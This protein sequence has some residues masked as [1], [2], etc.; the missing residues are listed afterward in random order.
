[1]R[2][3]RALLLAAA[4]TVGAHVSRSTSVPP[5]PAGNTSIGA[6]HTLPFLRCE[7]NL[8]RMADGNRGFLY[9]PD[10]QGKAVAIPI[11]KDTCTGPLP[12]TSTLEAGLADGADGRTVPGSA[13]AAKHRA[14]ELL[15][16]DSVR[17]RYAE[18]TQYSPLPREGRGAT[19]ALFAGTRHGLVHESAI[20]R[21]LALQRN[22]YAGAVHRV[23]GLYDVLAVSRLTAGV[24][25]TKSCVDL[26]AVDIFGGGG[27]NFGRRGRAC[28][29]HRYG[30]E[31]PILT[32]PA[33]GGGKAAVSVMDSSALTLGYRAFVDPQWLTRRAHSPWKPD[34][35][36][37]LFP[38]V[39]SEEAAPVSLKFKALQLNSRTKA[40]GDSSS[41][42]LQSIA[43]VMC[44]PPARSFVT[45]PDRLCAG[46]Q[47]G[48]PMIASKVDDKRST[49]LS[50]PAP[51]RTG[52]VNGRIVPSTAR[53][54]RQLG[55]RWDM[56]PFP[57]DSQARLPVCEPVR[58]ASEAYRPEWLKGVGPREI[59][60]ASVDEVA[61]ARNMT[62]CRL[63]SPAKVSITLCSRLFSLGTPPQDFGRITHE[64][65]Q[66]A[67]AFN[68]GAFGVD[69]PPEPSGV[70]SVLLA[71]IVV[72]P[73]AM[74]VMAMILDV[75]RWNRHGIMT[76]GLVWAA[77]LVSL[78]G[79]IYLASQETTGAAMRAATVR[80]TLAV[81]LDL[82][83][84][85]AR[86]SAVTDRDL[87]G[88]TLLRAETAYVVAR[89][90]YRPRMLVGIAAGTSVA[91]LL[92]SVAAVA[93][94]VIR[95]RVTQEE[96]GVTEHV[97]GGETAGSD[98]IEVASAQRPTRLP[99]RLAATARHV[100]PAA[101]RL[102]RDSSAD[103]EARTVRE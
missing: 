87:T 82:E 74:A 55:V 92:L 60:P 71:I 33:K 69:P 16:A 76:L 17:G 91:Y 38:P 58:D 53:S 100:W 66:L 27:N 7:T 45:N 101:L 67:Q 103:S 59:N 10:E 32:V 41:S 24:C 94:A 88:L 43:Y 8:P 19:D 49:M 77:G 72:L 2:L 62:S 5:F 21:A 31:V 85:V 9:Q 4:T 13:E 63:T 48:G 75:R 99:L 26:S 79:I 15:T 80:D 83:A 97:E 50:K 12:D 65:L 90:G 39:S 28:L 51:L 68:V 22:T 44:Q 25:Q 40:D 35:L 98:V 73:E 46:M 102:R 37:I 95:T 86:A 61:L 64:Q 1:M 30:G 29:G 18:N 78:S 84:E 93:I 23:T 81:E 47:S 36:V 96:G 89:T 3:A 57:N 52:L 56:D 70:A 54:L 11:G 14:A 20:G 42:W 6:F 34:A